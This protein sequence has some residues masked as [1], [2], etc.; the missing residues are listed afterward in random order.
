[1]KIAIPFAVFALLTGC[2][3]SGGAGGVEGPE[4][5]NGSP[6]INDPGSLAILEGG[7]EI[8]NLTAIDP[9]RD[10]LTFTIVAGDDRAL[11]RLTAAGALSFAAA[12]DYEIPADANANN[13]YEVSVQVSDGSLTDLQ[14]LTVNVTNAFEGR[15]VDGPI[16]NA[17]VSIDL[18]GNGVLDSDETSGVTDRDGYF[19]VPEFSVSGAVN[20]KVIATGGTDTFTEKVLTELTLISDVPSDMTKA[21]NVTPLTTVLSTL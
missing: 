10:S 9:D 18:N 6:S 19:K 14:S 8:A 7:L 3:G 2:G 4:P 1:M 5:G 20:P 15:V 17:S 16:S 21:A 13:V 12:P 11:F